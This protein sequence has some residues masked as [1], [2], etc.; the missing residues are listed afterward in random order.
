MMW[1]DSGDF[2]LFWPFF[3]VFWGKVWALR[4]PTPK[5]YPIAPRTVEFFRGLGKAWAVRWQMPKIRPKVRPKVSKGGFQRH[6]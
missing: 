3:G 1:L 5:I 6:V 4:R 2:G